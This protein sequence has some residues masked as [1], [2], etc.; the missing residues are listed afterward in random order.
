MLRPKTAKNGISEYVKT[1]LRRLFGGVSWA[2]TPQVGAARPPARP[3][4]LNAKAEHVPYLDS[5]LTQPAG[6]RDTRSD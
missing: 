2:A 6:L 5:K 1:G 4:A 3:G